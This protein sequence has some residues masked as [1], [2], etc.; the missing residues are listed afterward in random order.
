M[1][2]AALYIS[3]KFLKMEGAKGS[4]HSLKATKNEQLIE[5]DRDGLLSLCQ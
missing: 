2:H 3:L 5:L 1:L 4:V